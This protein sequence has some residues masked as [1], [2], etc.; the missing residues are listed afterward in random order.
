MG[1][2]FRAVH[3]QLNTP[4]ALKMVHARYSRNPVISTRFEREARA[5]ARLNHPGIISVTDLGRTEDGDL[6]LVMALLEGQSLAARLKE[7]PLSIEATLKIG[8]DLLY[9]LAVAHAAGI[10]HRDIKPDNLFIP[11]PPGPCHV[12]ILDF[13]IARVMLDTPDVQLTQ[14]G[15]YLGTPLY[16][17]PEQIGDMKSADHR[18][19]IYAAGAV[20]FVC[21]TGRLHV[22]GTGGEVLSRIVRG[23]VL[24]HP[25]EYRSDIPAWLDHI[26]SSALELKPSNRPPTASAMAAMLRSGLARLEPVGS[27]ES[28]E[29]TTAAYQT[30]V[31]QTG[32]DALATE[33]SHPGDEPWASP[34]PLGVQ[35][36]KM[37]PG[38]SPPVEASALPVARPATILKRV[39][40]A[41]ARARPA[42]LRL[43]GLA[44]LLGIAVTFRWM[45]LFEVP[46]SWRQDAYARM[47][48]PATLHPDIRL[49]DLDAGGGT[50]PWPRVRLARLL[51]KLLF[52]ANVQA[53]ILDVSMPDMGAPSE[54]QRLGNSAVASIHQRA[55]QQGRQLIMA[56]EGAFGR[57]EPGDSL[58]PLHLGAT[59][60]PREFRELQFGFAAL[61][62]PGKGGPVRRAP[63]V[64]RPEGH[65]EA[66]LLFSL[67]TQ[68]VADNAPVVIENGSQQIY[69]RGRWIQTDQLFRIEV[70]YTKPEG[71]DVIPA[72]K[73]LLEDP[74]PLHLVA[75]LKGRLAV[76]GLLSDPSIDVI[77]TPWG[78]RPGALIQASLMTD[79]MNGNPR[80]RGDPALEVTWQAMGLLAFA[81]LTQRSTP[82]R[83]RRLLVGA[84]VIGF[85]VLEAIAS[86]WLNLWIAGPVLEAGGAWLFFQVAGD[87]GR[88]KD[89]RVSNMS[90]P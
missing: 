72:S 67:A 22:E 17:S 31:E 24:R 74:V 90:D 21:L 43:G 9:A 1:V 83:R 20:L 19:D 3:C 65:A 44:C 45:G 84:A 27:A 51:E 86:V 87:V 25:G 23:E 36:G 68:G 61:Q 39:R 12:R 10:V 76:V 33:T 60:T 59:Q 53:V 42:V 80:F 6:F 78:R 7:G 77:P 69:V 35:P 89:P 52:E 29:L 50:W 16:S 63:L 37:S 54:D 71:Y 66:P 28:L 30:P 81:W 34:L 58:L 73:I 75:R 64:A 14:S 47:L 62:A 56:V 4:V 11:S 18:M 70:P 5:A 55:H 32:L 82:A 15:E 46:D 85:L 79:L 13:G 26:V 8:I 49:V 57:P 41:A 88:L 40:A 38:T 2:V 48:R